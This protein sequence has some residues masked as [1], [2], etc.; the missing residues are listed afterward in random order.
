MSTETPKP[1]PTAKAPAVIRAA[2]TTPGTL[3]AQPWAVRMQ[4][5]GKK[6]TLGQAKGLNDNFREDL[7]NS[8]GQLIGRTSGKQKKKASTFWAL[9]EI[10]LEI[11]R[12]DTVGIIGRN[13]AGK[14]TLL[15][16]LSRITAP[17]TGEMRYRGRLA[18]L[19]E[20]GTGFHRELSGRENIYLNGSILGMRRSEI[21]QHFDAIVDFAG[22]EKFLDTP[23]KFYSSGMYVRLAFA[24]AAHLRTDIL[25]VDEVLAVGDA[26]FQKKCLGKM[27]DV[28]QDGR[29]VLFVS[30]NM[31]AVSNL[32]K[33]GICLN[34]GSIDF[35]G[36]V[37]KAIQHYRS[38]D[39]ASGKSTT[40][41]TFVVKPEANANRKNLLVQSV[42]LQSMKGEFA[43]SI[44]MGQGMRITVKLNGFSKFQGAQIGII[45]KNSNEQWLG[46]LNSGMKSVKETI[47]PHEG[48][49]AVFELAT[50]PYTPGEYW[51]DV[52]I[53]QKGIGRLDYIDRAAKFEVI[54]N[55]VYGT[56]YQVTNYYGVTFID[57]IV[58]LRV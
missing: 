52:S 22:V 18:S 58:K 7:M 6:Y 10:N 34:Q 47:D 48:E 36:N 27:Q 31:T 40:Y 39:V 44:L 3:A 1:T 54:E 11:N 4:N 51:I 12:G 28:A 19:L 57:G 24:V 35:H 38:S 42:L 23:V 32:C 37:E 13:G 33:K 53:A 14:S 29:T 16:V 5:I 55:D 15:K 17:T 20:V 43:E 50:L 41:G 45:I 56:G 30:H 49:E 25:V 8:L 2:E 9:K 46:N 21:R 26:E